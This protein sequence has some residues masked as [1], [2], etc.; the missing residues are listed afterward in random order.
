MQKRKIKNIEAIRKELNL[1]I[2]EFARAV[3]VDRVTVW[4]WEAGQ[5]KPS[6]MAERIINHLLAAHRAIRL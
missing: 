5:S 6:R 4:R 1:G 3:G 2:N